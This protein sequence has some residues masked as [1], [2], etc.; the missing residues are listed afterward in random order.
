MNRSLGNLFF[1]DMTKSIIDFEKV[2]EEL[3][4]CEVQMMITW[5][6][7]H[8]NVYNVHCSGVMTRIKLGHSK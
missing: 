8:Y 1:K 7:G 5:M 3:S 4:I 6:D 2:L